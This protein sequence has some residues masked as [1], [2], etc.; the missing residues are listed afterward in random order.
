MGTPACTMRGFDENDF[1]EVGKI[2]AGALEDD[3]DVEALT[4]RSAALCDRNPLYP[5]FRGWTSYED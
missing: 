5:G 4:E 3:A 2:V 1:R